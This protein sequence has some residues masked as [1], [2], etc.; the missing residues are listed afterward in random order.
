VA[1]IGASSDP[2]K[3][4]G[5]TL[6]NLISY[7]YA[8]TVHAVN[9]RHPE[10]QGRAA[11]ASLRD[12]PGP[13]DMAAIVVPAAA[14]PA[15]VRDC[16]DKGVKSVVIFSA[17]FAE[18]D[19]AGRAAQAGIA[20][21][22]REAGMRVVGPNCM[23]A[24]NV[25]TSMF[26][27]FSSSFDHG[28]PQPGRI[29]IVS[30]SGAFGAH[31]FVGTRE[32]GLGL[33]L[34]VTTG[35]ECDVDF[36]ECLEFLVQ[37]PDTD[38]ILGYMEGCRDKDKL[39]RA[40]EAATAARKPVVMLKVG[41]SE[42][43]ARAAASHTASLVGS[44][45]VYTALFRR[46]GVFRAR[47]ISDLIDIGYACTAGKFPTQ[48]KL[49]LVSISG[50]V[51]VLMADEA[52][53]AG[54]DVPTLPQAAQDELKR[55]IPYA[56]VSNPVDTTAQVLNR[57]ELI[58]ENLRIM[59][60]AGGCDSVVMF[61]STVGMNPV[62]MENLGGVLHR[63]RE[64]FPDTL[65]VITTL[66]H[67]ELV[68]PLEESGY[69]LIEDPSR[70]IEVV[71]ALVS[72]GRHFARGG[73]RPAPPALPAG[74]PPLPATAPGE[75]EAKRILAAAG[76]PV[77][78]ERLARSPEQA[79]QAGAALGFPVAM[80]IHSRDIR[81]KSEVGGVLLNV[82]SREEAEAGYRAL[83][84]R[85]RKAAPAAALD[86]VL[87]APMIRD[88]V[89]TILGVHRD[90]VFGPVVMFGLGGIFVEVLKDVTVRVAPFSVEEAREMIREVQG[91]P[92]L[93]GARGRPRCDV[94]ALA[95][96]LARLSVYAAAQGDRLDSIDVNPFLVLPAGQGGC[97]VDA[98]IVPRGRAA[99]PD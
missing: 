26:C 81:H 31:C 17:G 23:G 58:G 55:I 96:A 46:H 69:L 65:V 20:A 1:V 2:K 59:L 44:D 10:V 6:R 41:R 40:L 5:R 22:A 12:V 80:K 33:S 25:R 53:D 92:L 88:G 47:G 76:I 30:Q 49:G 50:G 98:L 74:L 87:V 56:A 99:G 63:V 8:G 78:P 95:Q 3:I 28:M 7:G 38:V 9:S 48:G 29:G 72:Y 82:G 36:A 70:A 68:K 34:W 86:G 24:F 18:V 61:L 51:G 73:R 84:E 60:Q 32:R 21:L 19:A 77:A 83:L 89:E 93:D 54:L 94:E 97:A 13:V 35:N 57:I 75:H 91:F 42:L 39:V 27:T 79:G 14:V 15:A 16:A 62:M 67:R 64:R 52:A 85:V 43:G 71:A 11:V 66:M 4:S 90:E 37:D 45:A